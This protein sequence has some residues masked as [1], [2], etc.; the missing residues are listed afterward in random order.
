MASQRNYF[1]SYETSRKTLNYQGHYQKMQCLN[2]YVIY[3]VDIHYV[4]FILC[5]FKLEY[6]HNTFK[7]DHIGFKYLLNPINELSNQNHAMRNGMRS[8]AN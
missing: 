1:C 6:N 3:Y 5:V 8:C 2:I 7:S 4:N